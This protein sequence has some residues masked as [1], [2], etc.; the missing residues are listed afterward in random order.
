MLKAWEYYTNSIGLELVHL[1][2]RSIENRCGQ[3]SFARLSFEHRK[4]RKRL[5]TFL[6]VALLSWSRLEVAQ[7]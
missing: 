6:V 5:D 7:F 3:G 2:L 4:S 1:L